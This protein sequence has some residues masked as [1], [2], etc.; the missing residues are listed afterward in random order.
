MPMWRDAVRDWMEREERDQAYLARKSG[1]SVSHMSNIMTG[2]H[3]PSLETLRRFEE[4][5]GLE[6]GELMKLR[7]PVEAKATTQAG[8]G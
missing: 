7:G 8:E 6:F 4:V 1:L 5:M 2:K 3:E